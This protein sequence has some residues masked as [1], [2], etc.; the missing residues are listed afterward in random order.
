MIF[1]HVENKEKDVLI[2]SEGP[3]QGLDGTT[4]TTEKSNQ[5]ILLKI[6]RKVV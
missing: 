4:L 5:L 3:T 6:T 1:V 2:P